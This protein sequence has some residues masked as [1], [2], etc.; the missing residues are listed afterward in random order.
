NKDDVVVAS[1]AIAWAIKGKSTDYQI[2]IAVNHSPTIHFP[3]GIPVERMR[4]DS[5]ISNARYVIWDTILESWNGT[6]IPGIEKWR[7]EILN[8]WKPIFQTENLIVFENPN[9]K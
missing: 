4:F 6:Q 2:S 3:R 5:K 8:H 7:K 9:L 1:P